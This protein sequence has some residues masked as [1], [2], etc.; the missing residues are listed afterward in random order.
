MGGLQV[1]SNGLAARLSPRISLAL[2]TFIAATGYLV[3]ALPLGFGGL[4]IGLVLAGI[5]SSVQH[6]RASMLVTNS[7]GK[8]LRGPLSIYNFA[9]DLG[10]ATFP[11][12]VALTLP[13]CRM[14]ACHVGLTAAIGLVM[15]LPLRCSSFYRR[16]P[17]FLRSKPKLRSRDRTAGASTY[18]L[19]SAH[20]I[21]RPE[22]AI[23]CSFRFSSREKAATEQ[24]W[25]LVLPCFSG[26]EPWARR[27]A[28]GSAN[29]SGSFGA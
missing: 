13:L 19:R 26:E 6:P 25:V 7:Y 10:K 23:C 1:P 20:S 11:A 28:G 29:I 16:S 22:W 21:L 3:V 8:A 14:A 4:C 9:G 18:S 17:S 15:I 5:G 24:P 27:A 2:A 12:V